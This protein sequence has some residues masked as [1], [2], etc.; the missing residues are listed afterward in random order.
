MPDEEVD[1]PVL[2]YP[3][4]KVEDDR[5]LKSKAKSEQPDHV[6]PKTDS[7]KPE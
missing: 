6:I 2:T 4:G 1:G 7:R 3:L 5:Q